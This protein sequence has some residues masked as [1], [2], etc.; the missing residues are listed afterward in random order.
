LTVLQVVPKLVTRNGA[1]H[2]PLAQLS[3]A[4][5]ARLHTPQFA[6]LLFKSTHVID[7]P[8]AVCPAGHTARHA[9]ATQLCPAAHRL[10]HAPQLFGSLS[11]L[12]HTP[13]AAPH[14][15][16]PRLQ[17]VP[18]TPLEHEASPLIG[19]GHERPHTPQCVTEK[20]TSVSQP[21]AALPSQS[22]KPAAQRNKHAPSEHV[23]L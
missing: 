20:F 5:H 11:G 1:M 14:S 10:P 23:A 2:A 18:H 17:I 22:P 12:A 6:A 4:A 13:G 19:A 9:P 3:P 8:Q 21:L 16:S 15:K 7:G